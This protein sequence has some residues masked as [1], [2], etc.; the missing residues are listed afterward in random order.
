MGKTFTPFINGNLIEKAGSVDIKKL[1]QALLNGYSG[2]LSA[3]LE[4]EY[5][6]SDKVMYDLMRKLDMLKLEKMN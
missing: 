1:I 2:N 4:L 5:E 6:I 3:D